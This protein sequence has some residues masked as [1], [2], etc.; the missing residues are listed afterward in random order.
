MLVIDRS[1]RLASG[2]GVVEVGAPACVARHLLQ[3]HCDTLGFDDDS[4]RIGKL[5]AGLLM[6]EVMV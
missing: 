1:G 6:V 5:N 4:A 3:T 2:I